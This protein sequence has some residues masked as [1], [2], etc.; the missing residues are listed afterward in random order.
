MPP[1]E[2]KIG[3]VSDISC[4][5]FL[6]RQPIIDRSRKVFGYELLYRRG[7]TSGAG[8]MSLADEARSLASALVEIGLNEL[9]GRN[10]AFINV[11][12]ELIL[13]KSL[14][15]FPNKR[16]VLEVL[17]HVNPT[18]E[19]QDELKRLRRLGYTIALDDFLWNDKTEPLLPLVDLVKVDVTQIPA[20]EM[21]GLVSDL[22]KFPVKLLAERVETPEEFALYDRLGYDL[23]Q[24]YFFAKPQVMKGRAMSVNHLALVRL[25]TRLNADDL[26]MDELEG[27]IASEVQLS[28]RLL[29]FIKSAYMGLPTTVDSIRKA[30]LFVGVRTLAAIATLL[31]MSQFAHKPDELVFMAMI[32]AKMADT[33]GQRDPDPE[34]YFTTGMLSMLG[35]L[36]DLPMEELLAQMP[37]S[38][39]INEALLNPQSDDLLARVLRVIRGY[40]AG[41]FD[42]AEREGISLQDVN[43]AYR[44]AVAWAGQTRMAL[45]A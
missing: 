23:F 34:P 3:L 5:V 45:A 7:E 14:D 25:L 43:M 21:T 4:P 32:R 24:G 22:R 33:L 10:R 11:S 2:P 36:M 16:V 18:P 30:L 6:A 44:Q 41:D 38:E 17:E 40:E 26:T 8:D 1:G 39:R 31:M 20:P 29:K 19:V 37:L 9:V 13:S 35:A 15:A 28:V 12:E 27:I 42:V